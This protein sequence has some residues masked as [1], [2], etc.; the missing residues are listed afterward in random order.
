M[1]WFFDHMWR[2]MLTLP[3][4][5]CVILG[6][7]FNCTLNPSRDRVDEEPHSP[8]A[9]VLQQV[10]A[11]L[12]LSDIWCVQHPT[13]K[14]FSST[15]IRVGDISQSRL[16]RFYLSQHCCRNASCF[17]IK[18]AHFADYNLAWI[19]LS[20]AEARHGTGFRHLNNAFV[21]DEVL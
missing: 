7:D 10:A 3:D 9:K 8:S 15:S 16:D 20:P 18:F 6:G 4:E 12:N 11:L 2:Y 13:D 5:E 14:S 17:G 21:K 19:K 1:V